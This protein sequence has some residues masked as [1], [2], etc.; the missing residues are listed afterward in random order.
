[1]YVN[2]PERAEHV[3]I[4]NYTISYKIIIIRL[5]RLLIVEVRFSSY[6]IY[7]LCVLSCTRKIQ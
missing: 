5:K 1:M 6:H 4:Y 3:N 7:F 2:C